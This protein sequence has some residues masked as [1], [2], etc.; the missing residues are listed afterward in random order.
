NQC[1]KAL[2]AYAGRSAQTV[3]GGYLDH[4]ARYRNHQPVVRPGCRPGFRQVDCAGYSR[5]GLSRPRGCQKL[6]RRH[7]MI[8]LQGVRAGYGAINILWDVSLS[9]RQGELTTIIG[10]NGA[11][12]TTLLRAIMGLMPLE[13]GVVQLDG[14]VLNGVPTWRMPSLGMVMIPEGRMVF[15]E[16]TV[17][18]NLM[19]GAFTK[20][21]RAGARKQCD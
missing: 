8:E 6:Y 7:R 9:I 17:E 13:Q 19:L 14:L 3:F 1:Q 18:E 15:K 2:H 12:K 4:R 20:Q 21:H 16:M 10:P 5:R 11:G